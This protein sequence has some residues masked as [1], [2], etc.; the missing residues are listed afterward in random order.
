MKIC[1]PEDVLLFGQCDFYAVSFPGY[2]YLDIRGKKA[3]QRSLSQAVK[4]T[5]SD[6]GNRVHIHHLVT[7]EISILRSLA[8][9]WP[10]HC[11]QKSALRLM[12]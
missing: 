6:L 4:K 8:D 11:S 10:G 5:E 3:S 12:L 9:E 7:Q 1:E 2:F